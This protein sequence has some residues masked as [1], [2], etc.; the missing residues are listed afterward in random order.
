MPRVG[1]QGTPLEYLDVGAGSPVVLVH[2]SASDV[3][4]WQGQVEPLAVHHRVIAYSRRFHWPNEPIADG[5]DYAM[6]QQVDDLQALLRALGAVPAHLVGHSYGAFVCLLLALRD[7]TLVRSLVLAEP[8]AI[9]LFVSPEPKPGE[10]LKLLCTRP[11][12]AA[13]LARFGAA[14]VAPARKAFRGGDLQA[15]VRIFG[16]A[17]FG[18]GGFE[19]LPAGRR[20]QVDDNLPNIKAEILGSGFAPLR[21][22]ALRSLRLPALLVTG[23]RSQP[24]FRHLIDRL[25]ELL[26]RTQRVDIPGAS[27]AMHDDD[28]PAF[29]AAVLGFL[30]EQAEGGS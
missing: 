12:T 6:L 24:L 10:L 7:P 17:V 5:V 14:G 15:G 3:R 2:G 23:E 27:H 9:T 20:Q 16:D 19:R 29:N 13:A 21:G 4:S 11:A 26:P 28:P 22:E 18:R 25:E 8:P 30:E 1:V